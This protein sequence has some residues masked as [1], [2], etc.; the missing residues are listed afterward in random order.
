MCISILMSHARLPGAAMNKNAPVCKLGHVALTTPDLETSVRFF[1]ELVGLDV[2]DAQD[3]AVYLRA[4]GEHEHHSL[5]LR[6]G[7]AG[8]D[9][10]GLRAS[11][12]EQLDAIAAAV[13]ADGVEVERIEPGEELG[14][15]EAIRFISPQG[16]P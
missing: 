2:V 7:P 5:V 12:P 14:Q 16:H 6:E 9:H 3:D 4:W 10:F 13:A 8:V 1:S 11:G 15:G